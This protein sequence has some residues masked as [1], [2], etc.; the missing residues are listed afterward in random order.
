MSR[1]LHDVDGSSRSAE[2]ALDG[3]GDGEHR[4]VN[5]PE[6]AAE[7]AVEGTELVPDDAAEQGIYALAASIVRALTPGMAVAVDA[8]GGRAPPKAGPDGVSGSLCCCST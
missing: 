3:T 8:N 6:N 7:D 2:Q 5:A 1:T 4:G